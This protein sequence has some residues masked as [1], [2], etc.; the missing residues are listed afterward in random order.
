MQC[1]SPSAF[2]LQCSDRGALVLSR[3]PDLVP[4][5]IRNL[6]NATVAGTAFQLLDCVLQA[7]LKQHDHAHMPELLKQVWLPHVVAAVTSSNI[8]FRKRATEVLLPGLARRF[9]PAL[10]LLL[11]SAMPAATALAVINAKQV[12]QPNWVE[13][14]ADCAVVLV[15]CCQRPHISHRSQKC[16]QHRDALVRID[17]LRFVCSRR[18]ITEA[19]SETEAAV[20][21]A[22]LPAVAKEQSLGRIP[23]RCAPLT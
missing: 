6:A 5:S 23:D 10:D 2:S 21:L 9:P 18:R 8:E 11:E 22:A 7:Q 17:A 1:F 3:A 15:Q 20:V 12:A 19:V 13:T 4:R 14:A 16:A